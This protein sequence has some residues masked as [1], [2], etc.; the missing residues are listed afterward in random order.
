MCDPDGCC[1]DAQLIVEMDNNLTFSCN[2][3]IYGDLEKILISVKA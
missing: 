1:T 3:N 2:V